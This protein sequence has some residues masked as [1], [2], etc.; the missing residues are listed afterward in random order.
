LAS[1]S[2]TIAAST[3]SVGGRL[4]DADARRGFGTREIAWRLICATRATAA[5][6]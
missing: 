4:G 2:E 1:A 3:W 6:L 5:G